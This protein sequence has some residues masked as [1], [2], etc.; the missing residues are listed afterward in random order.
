MTSAKQIAKAAYRAKMEVP[1]RI[2]VYKLKE[3]HERH[4]SCLRELLQIQ[5]I[6]MGIGTPRG[7]RHCQSYEIASWLRTLPIH[8]AQDLGGAFLPA[9]LALEGDGVERGLLSS[10]VKNLL[11]DVR[12]VFELVERASSDLKSGVALEYSRMKKGHGLTIEAAESM[13]WL[14]KKAED[15]YRFA[16]C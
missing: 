1:P 16:A 5:K 6:K 12:L 13:L 14:D 4:E 2:G 10:F 7:L 9:V 11:V 8:F 3:L 15:F